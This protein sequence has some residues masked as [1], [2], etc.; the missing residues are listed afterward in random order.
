[1]PA[2]FSPRSNTRFRRTLLAAVALAVAVPLGLMAWVRLPAATGEGRVPS[3]PVAF[4]HALHV[5]GM[6]IDCRYCHYTVERTR[7]AGVPSTTTCVPCHSEIWLRGALFAPV[8][9]SLATALPLAWNRVHAL[10][11]HSYFHHG[12]HV[13]R[14]I[15]C[16]TCHGRVDRMARI[17]QHA[18]L[19]MGWCLDCH[20]E[21]ERHLR[22]VEEVTTMGWTPDRPQEVLG[23]ELKA[24]YGIADAR[25]LTDCSVCHR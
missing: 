18:P 3:Q 24:R 4:N 12:A 1:M 22:P 25:W 8:R 10:P 14:G 21:P 9:T 15:G 19:T 7:Y 5:S 17:E 6:R 16:E 2:L 11:D 20:R 23:A 13:S